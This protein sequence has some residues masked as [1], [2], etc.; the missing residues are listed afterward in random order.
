M[1][2]SFTC[3]MNPVVQ[4]KIQ[5][6]FSCHSRKVTD[7]EVHNFLHHSIFTSPNEW[8]VG[9]TPGEPCHNISVYQMLRGRKPTID[10]YILMFERNFF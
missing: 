10:E 7:I 2:F 6:L 1:K 9:L 5:S 8:P 3:Q 4:F